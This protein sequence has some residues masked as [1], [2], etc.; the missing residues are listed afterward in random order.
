MRISEVS[1]KNALS[2]SLEDEDKEMIEKAKE[3]SKII[4]R[5]C[6]PYL[7]QIDENYTLYR[8]ISYRSSLAGEYFEK[9][10]FT[11]RRIKD[12]SEKLSNAINEI[13]KIH[14]SPVRRENSLFTTSSHSDALQYGSV[15]V[16]FPIGKFDFAWS[17]DIADP[18]TKFEANPDKSDYMILDEE[19]KQQWKDDNI[20]NIEVRLK[21]DLEKKIRNEVNDKWVDHY[22]NEAQNYINNLPDN[23]PDRYSENYKNKLVQM[24]YKKSR[25]ERDKEVDKKF[26]QEYLDKDWDKKV[27]E[28]VEKEWLENAYGWYPAAWLTLDSDR[29]IKDFA[30][31]YSTS[32]LK[33]AIDSE[34][35]IMIKA[36]SYYAVRTNFYEY[37]LKDELWP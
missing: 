19:K 36:K 25:P 18:Y 34:N 21:E 6:K 29:V 5:R 8:G 1:D 14:N 37:F 32:N 31:T 35:E 33:E 15:Y 26:D 22:K 4:K 12:S 27:N 3:A 13:L 11:D 17:E 28:E 10:V 2:K 9:E 20:K 23:D 16:V 24:W 7:S 30:K